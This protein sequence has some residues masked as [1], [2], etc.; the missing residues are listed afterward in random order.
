M[1]RSSLVSRSLAA[2]KC[3]SHHGEKNSATHACF[4]RGGVRDIIAERKAGHDRRRLYTPAGQSL[5]ELDGEQ[6]GEEIEVLRAI[7]PWD[8]VQVRVTKPVTRR[9]TKGDHTAQRTALAERADFQDNAIFTDAAWDPDTFRGA[10]AAVRGQQRDAQAFQYCQE[11]P[12]RSLEL[13]AILYALEKL[14]ECARTSPLSVR[15]QTFTIFTDSL[16]A[17]KNLT[18]T[19]RAGTL[20]HNVK[21]ACATLHELY[22]VTVRVDWVPG[23]AGGIGNGAAHDAASELLRF[24]SS[25]LDT[26]PQASLLFDPD[27]E[28]ERMKV[29]AK[30][31]LRAKVPHN[32]THFPKGFPRGAE[33]LIHKARTGAALREDVLASGEHTLHP[34][35]L[36]AVTHKWTS[37][38]RTRRA[39]RQP[40]RRAARAIPVPL[41]R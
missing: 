35:E 3:Q 11:Q 23:H 24:R 30:R 4:L 39:T 14:S 26:V 40:L 18:K 22:G 9:R 17:L 31:E 27:E 36:V 28:R 2:G 12:V 6:L 1:S 25:P 16:D 38:I 41:Q 21:V 32:P 34:K 33:V 13:Q 20:A 10:V 29:Q 37:P 19:P 5:L 8:D 7:A 15:G